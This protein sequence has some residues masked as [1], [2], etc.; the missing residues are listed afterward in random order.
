LWTDGALKLG[1]LGRRGQREFRARRFGVR[2]TGSAADRQ[3]PAEELFAPSRAGDTWLV[4][5]L[6]QPED[7]YTAEEALHAAYALLD[8]RV[9]PSFKLM[10][11]VRLERFHQQ[12]D[13][14]SPFAQPG[15]MAAD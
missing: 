14:A 7:G 4:N 11:G 6:T 8:A 15:R 10:G 9:A 5:E 2:Y 12:I 1:Y 3:L 13:V